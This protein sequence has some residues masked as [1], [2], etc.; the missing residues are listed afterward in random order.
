MPASLCL[1][2]P[3]L[4]TAHLWQSTCSWQKPDLL[5]QV[6]ILN[7]LHYNVKGGGDSALYGVEPATF[8]L[9]NGLNNLNLVL[10]LGLAYPAVAVLHL[11]RVTGEQSKA[12]PAR[13][14][15][16]DA[17]APGGALA[18]LQRLWVTGGGF[19]RHQAGKTLI[20]RYPCVS[21]ALGWHVCTP[22]K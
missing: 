6:S 17:D 11:L 16:L 2:A 1:A 7:F 21:P 8:Y 9:R 13:P 12:V 19:A 3:S 5:W 20:W 14:A 22:C 15:Q 10:P 18:L 4:L